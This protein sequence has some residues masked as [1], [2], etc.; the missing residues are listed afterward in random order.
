MKQRSVFA[1]LLDL[2]YPRKCPFCSAVLAKDEGDLCARCRD[3]LPYVE[4]GPR[5]DLE[6]IEE[7]V[8]PLWFKD[9]VRSSILRFKFSGRTAYAS[10]Y[11]R[12]MAKWVRD[13]MGGSE[14]ITWVPLSK[15]RCARRGYDQARLLA[16]ELSKELGLPCVCLLRKSGDNAVQSTL[17]DASARRA[18]VLGMYEVTD[19]ALGAGKKVLLVD[20]VVTTG[21]TL[22]ECAVTL[23]IRGAEEVRAVTAARAGKTGKG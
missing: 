21:A 15:K 19:P 23:L 20:D 16:E 10:V 2:I 12:L 6:G 5:R 22:S 1:R 14:I 9:R 13:H 7:C 4:R 3:G 11:A 17:R 18:N 8:S